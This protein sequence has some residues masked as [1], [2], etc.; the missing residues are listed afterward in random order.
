MT[1]SDLRLRIRALFLRHRTEQELDEELQFHLDM[2]A[3]MH[4]SEARKRFGSLDRVKEECRTARGTQ[5]LETSWRDILYALRGFQRN[6][7]FVVTVVGTIALG[8]GLNVA[9]FTLFN[10]IVFRPY[11][12]RDPYSLY[13]FTWTNRAGKTHAFSWQEFEQFR[14]TNPAFS[15]I[16]A[17]D[18]LRGRMSGHPAQG[19]LVTGN[20][21][22]MLGGSAHLGRVLAPEDADAPGRE[23]VVVLGFSAWVNKFGGDTN[24]IGKKILL[25]GYPLQV[26]G[27][28]DEKFAGLQISAPDFWIP[29][30]MAAQLEDGPDLFGPENPQR[31]AIVGRLRPNWLASQAEAALDTWSKQATSNLPE[32]ERAVGGT[33]QSQAPAGAFNREAIMVFSPL[34]AAFGLVLLIACANVANMMLARSMARQREIGI[35]LSLGAGRSRL[36]R[37]LLTESMLLA[38]PAGLASFFVSRLAIDWA[39]RVIWATLPSDLVALVPGISLPPDLRVFVFM[40]IA[41]LASAVLFGL[42][43]AIQATRPDVMAAARGEFTSD[44]RP[45]RFRNSLVMGQIAVCALLL[46]CSGVLIRAA[47]TMRGLDVGFQTHGV[48]FM[49]VSEKSRAKLLPRLSAE[50]VVAEI[51]VASSIPLV[52]EPPSFNISAVDRPTAMRAWQNYVSTE[53]FSLLQVPILDGRNFTADEAKAGAPVVIISE[54]AAR[55]LWPKG[56]AVGREIRI[57]RDLQNGNGA[58]PRYQ[59]VRVVGVAGNIITSWVNGGSDPPLVYFP[60]TMLS[61]NPLLLRVRGDVEAVRRELVAD[62]DATLPGAIEEVHPMDQWFAKDVYIFR[63]A[64]WIGSALGVLALLLTLSGIYGVLSY[65]ITQRT[66]EIG[67]RMAIGASAGAVTWLVLKQSA[68]LAVVGIGLGA[69]LALGVSRLMA[70]LLVLVNTFDPMAYCGGML[71]VAMASFA[72]AYIPSRRAA[73]IDPVTTLRY[74]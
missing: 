2:D 3:R 5:L 50:P 18:Y 49:S 42:A 14:K 51:A 36:I 35:R 45:M 28:A 31:L 66:K 29:I 4:G 73:R 40:L 63:M 32:A 9:L 30:T 23:P 65:L 69:A 10:T 55:S 24:I 47:R 43:P 21:F 58:S 56:D 68:R 11:A 1:W 20:F 72:A 53:F 22:Q 54:Y 52:G 15:E 39:L 48:I 71:L 25:R 8:L 41:A 27:V 16:L 61:N 34:F 57:E 37:Q 7:L 64:S 59:L 19:F 62:L 33:L 60:A 67:I 12:V 44:I 70:Y 17:A 13:A 74:D 6:P 38:I 26:V 46:I